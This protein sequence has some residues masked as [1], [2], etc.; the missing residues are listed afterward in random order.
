[1]RDVIVNKTP[2]FA[3]G[4]LGCAI[5]GTGLGA[6]A[7]SMGT[8]LVAVVRVQL[9]LQVALVL[10]VAATVPERI[11][12]LVAVALTMVLPFGAFVAWAESTLSRSTTPAFMVIGLGAGLVVV[13]AWRAFSG[14]RLTQAARVTA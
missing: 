7:I 4:W 9:A 1:M 8:S 12:G 2:W 5:A 3:L 13:A 14:R 10:A 11:G 6:I